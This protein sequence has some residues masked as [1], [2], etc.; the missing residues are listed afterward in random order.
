MS[1]HERPTQ[2]ANKFFLTLVQ[3]GVEVC[4][5]LKVDFCNLCALC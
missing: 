4:V 1:G 5:L 2:Y 3:Q